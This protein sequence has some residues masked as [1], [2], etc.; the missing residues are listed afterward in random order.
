MLLAFALTSTWKNCLT[1]PKLPSCATRHRFGCGSTGLQKRWGTIWRRFLNCETWNRWAVKL[2]D[3]PPLEPVG[4]D[5]NS[6]E[7][8]IA[9]LSIDGQRSVAAI[10]TA[11]NLQSDL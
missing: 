4:G 2:D 10:K 9:H 6:P 1:H 3:L 5:F 11:D 8:D 7:E